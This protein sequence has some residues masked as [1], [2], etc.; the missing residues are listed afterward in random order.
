MSIVAALLRLI[1]IAVFTV[2]VGMT[3]A[4]AVASAQPVVAMASHVDCDTA[5]TAPQDESCRIHCLGLSMLPALATTA[6]HELRGT[7]LP[8]SQ[9]AETAPS[10]WPNPE[11]HP[12]RL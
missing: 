2:G 4:P 10:L 5:Q 11:P 12:P 1:L 3:A 8:V 6:P 7:A 9:F